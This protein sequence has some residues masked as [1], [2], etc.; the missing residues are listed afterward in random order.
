[1]KFLKSHKESSKRWLSRQFKDP[2]VAKAKQDGYRAR[3]AY[4]ILEMHQKFKLF[5]RNRRVLDLGAAPGG[6]SQVAKSFVGDDF[7][8]AI[9]LLPIDPIAGV[10]IITGDFTVYAPQLQSAYHGVISDM[11]P[12]T[13]GL[14]KVDHI[15][16]MGL[17][18]EA[19]LFAKEHLEAGGFFVAKVFVGGTELGL[20]NDLKRHFQ[21]V[22]HFKPKSSRSESK[23]IYVVGKGF[24]VRS[25]K[26][27]LEQTPQIES[28]L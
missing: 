10:N 12:S 11:A 17:V 27:K 8:D 25:P 23:E 1:M 9:D 14:S 19:W 15:R 20:L 6:W 5:K 28:A 16:I 21:S 26:P 4:K 3:S 2:F 13:C 7:V 22:R 24:I 18:E